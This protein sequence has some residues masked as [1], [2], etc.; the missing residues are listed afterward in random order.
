MIIN[1]LIQ[2]TIIYINKYITFK[3]SDLP[4]IIIIYKNPYINIKYIVY[5][6]YYDYWIVFYNDY[7]L[8]VLGFDNLG[9]DI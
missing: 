9:F 2:L 4:Y 8:L 3:K 7:I 1:K 6:N 5:F